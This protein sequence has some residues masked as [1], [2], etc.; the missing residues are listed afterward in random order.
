LQPARLVDETRRRI[1]RSPALG[2]VAAPGVRGAKGVAASRGASREAIR[3]SRASFQADSTMP[4]YSPGSR[5]QRASSSSPA[6]A[7]I[8][9]EVTR[10]RTSYPRRALDAARCLI[11]AGSNC[12][13]QLGGEG[14]PFLHSVLL[15]ED[16]MPT[17]EAFVPTPELRVNDRV[18]SDAELQ[19]GDRISIGEFEF[20]LHLT[21]SAHAVPAVPLYIPHPRESVDEEAGENLAELSVSELV[22][23]IEAAEADVE[24]FESARA[25]GAAALLDAAWLAG[26]PSAAAAATE[27]A[28]EEQ[29]LAELT[30][31][32]G[33][34]ESQL[35]ELRVRDRQHQSR[36]TE[37]LTAQTKLAE[38]LKSAA[39]RLTTAEAKPRA[40][41]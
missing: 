29:L 27:P 18:V 24:E 5:A 23:R 14:M 41:A 39:D 28:V 35:A 21:P 25:A 31:L 20:T 11:G 8:W 16:G 22:E 19:N 40:I 30:G 7:A 12:Q 37:L 9:I 15:I 33:E 34:I 1:C 32:A 3:Q 38:Q 2:N 26:A 17:I 13:L 6:P 4:I 36:A 10:G